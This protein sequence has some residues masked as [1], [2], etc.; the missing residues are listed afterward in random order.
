MYMCERII[1]IYA[2][3]A[4]QK[5]YKLKT[6]H[7]VAPTVWAWK[8]YRAKK[9]ANFIDNLFVLFPFE[10]KYFLPYGIKTTFIGHPFIN[11]NFKISPL[12]VF[13]PPKQNPEMIEAERR[14]KAILEESEREKQRNRSTGLAGLLGLE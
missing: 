7:I 4:K 14:Y 1:C 3:K 12:P 11:T 13:Q 6:L 2:K 5:N 9:M 8:A 10:K